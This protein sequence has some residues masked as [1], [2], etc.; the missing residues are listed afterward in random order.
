M[1]RVLFGEHRTQVPAIERLI[2][3]ARFDVAFGFDAADFAAF[4]LVVPLR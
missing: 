2:D 1:A 4:D 3:R